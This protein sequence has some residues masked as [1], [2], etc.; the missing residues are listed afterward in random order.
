MSFLEEECKNVRTQISSLKEAVKFEEK[1]ACIGGVLD[2]LSI[3]MGKARAQRQSFFIER[4]I[5]DNKNASIMQEKL[6]DNIREEV[7]NLYNDALENF[8]QALDSLSKRMRLKVRNT[9]TGEEVGVN[10][11]STKDYVDYVDKIM[12]HPDY[13]GF[14]MIAI[15]KTQ[16][17]VIFLENLEFPKANK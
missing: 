17:L 3:L 8:K 12:Q 9:V 6:R 2:S 5:V 15:T 13:T 11:D 4:I 1:I 7:E 14:M 16:D 10:I